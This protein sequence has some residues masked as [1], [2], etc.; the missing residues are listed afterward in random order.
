MCVANGYHARRFWIIP[1]NQAGCKGEFEARFLPPS[2]ALRYSPLSHRA[3]THPVPAPLAL[4]RFLRRALVSA[5]KNRSAAPLTA[6]C[7]VRWTRSLFVPPPGRAKTKPIGYCLQRVRG[8]CRRR[9]RRGPGAPERGAKEKRLLTRALLSI[10]SIFCTQKS[11][12][13]IRNGGLKS[14]FTE[15]RTFSYQRF[16]VSL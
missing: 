6:P 5:C 3:L 14:N 7:F 11:R 13:S 12:R 8:R 2:Q 4:S 15:E 10:V 9:R 16:A 1:Q